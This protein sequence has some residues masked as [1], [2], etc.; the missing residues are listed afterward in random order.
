MGETDW[1]GSWVLFWW[2]SML[3]KSLIQF[4]ADGQG[5]VPSLLFENAQTSTIAFISHTRE[6]MNKTQF[7]PQSV[8]PIRKLPWASYPSPS[9]CRE[10]ENHNRRKLTNLITWTTALSNSV[11]L[12]AMPCGATQDRRVI[13]EISDKMWSTGE[14][15]GNPLQYSC[16]GNPM[17]S[18]KRQKDRTLKEEPPQVGRCPICYWIRV[19]K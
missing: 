19:E 4:S 18:M 12:W 8:S 11:K 7:P 6:V 9:E 10:T 15:N 2:V 3:S 13:M 16:L 5:C 14:G 1:G 17:N